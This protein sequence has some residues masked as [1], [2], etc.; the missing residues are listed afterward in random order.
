MENLYLQP[1]INEYSNKP[2]I[3][4]T[5]NSQQGIFVRK[6]TGIDSDFNSKGKYTKN[7]Q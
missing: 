1:A 6:G 4:I 5:T 3:D 2:T 7:F